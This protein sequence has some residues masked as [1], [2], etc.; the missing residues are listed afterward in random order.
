[1]PVIFNQFPLYGGTSLEVTAVANPTSSIL[2]KQPVLAN[3]QVQLNFTVTGAATTFTL[4]QANRLGAAW[5]TN[6]S[7][8]LTTNVPG[9][10]YRFTAAE[11]G[12]TEFYRIQSP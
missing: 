5:T 6:S 12:A 7:A 4:L 8:T 11:S 1:M 9:S 2:L 10:S 3:G